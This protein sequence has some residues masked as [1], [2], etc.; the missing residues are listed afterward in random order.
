M[1]DPAGP[2]RDLPLQ[3]LDPA[4][5]DA[6][7]RSIDALLGEQLARVRKRY[8]VHGL[9]TTLLLPFLVVLAAFALDHVLRLPTPIRVFHTLLTLSALGFAG[10][11]FLWYPATRKF[12]A[13]DA[14]V[15]LE[16]AFPQL[17][18][19]LISAVQLKAALQRGDDSALRNQSPAMIEGLVADAA[20]AARALPLEQLFLPTRTRQ[21]WTAAASLAVLLATG[22]ALS[23]ET[24]SAFFWRHL[25]LD[26]SYPRET[27]LTVELPE[28]SASMQRTDSGSTTTLVVPA[29]ADLPVMVLAEGVVPKEVFLDLTPQNGP[30]RS[31]ATAPRPGDRFRHVFRRVNGGFTFRARGGDDDRGDREVTVV[32]IHPPLVADVKVELTPPAYTRKPIEVQTGGS[33]EALLGTQAQIAVRATQ[34]VASAE[35][36]FLESNKR[37]PLVAREVTDDSGTTTVL[38]GAFAVEQSDRY[39]VL[40]TGD[41][42]LQNP[43]PGAYPISALQDYAP[44]GR[45][46]CPDDEAN[47]PLLPEGILCVRA[48]ARDDFGLQ[49]GQLQIDA[50]QDRVTKKDL[51]AAPAAGDEP[52]LS[53]LFLQL[54]E[55]KDLLPQQGTTDGLALQVE[56]VDNKDPQANATQLPRRQVQIVDQAQ[57]SAAIA[58]HFRSLREEAE[59]AL[60][61]QNDRR[62]RLTDLIASQPRPSAA[63]AQEITAVEVGQGRIQSASERLLRGTMRAF[64]LHLWN[65]LD[66]SPAA[67]A[68]VAFYQTWHEQN[69]EAQS[70]QPAFYRALQ[71]ERKKGSIGAMEQSLDPILRMVML[72]DGLAAELSPPLLRELQKAQVAPDAAAL[73]AGLELAL[74]MQDRVTASLQEMLSKL[75]EWND[76]QDLVQEARSLIEKQRDV[77]S[78]TQQTQGRK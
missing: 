64:D 28:A 19:R 35:L 13:D 29:G 71:E 1:T 42:G 51:L 62:A 5:R 39:R 27:R 65:R 46:L 50:G 12:S 20:A 37:L 33:I 10:Y 32:T 36:E 60:D 16:R 2:S 6:L 18:E 30:M 74:A 9:A 14:A 76:Y 78:R 45:W 66:P 63:V 11:R 17:H 59:Q 52:R 53:R 43:N 22:A 44:V 49:T 21:L 75:D 47:T 41:G 40:L 54:L 56:F 69:G 68:A 57:L 67:P 72:A 25:G 23:P 31:I 55:L 15:M 3:P 26:V 38:V 4:A 73:K 48:E 7:A 58:R 34:K 70:Y 77:Q 8:V 24:A 61:L